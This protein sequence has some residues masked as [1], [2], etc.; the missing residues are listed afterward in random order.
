MYFSDERSETKFAKVGGSAT[1]NSLTIQDIGHLPYH[2][3]P[4]R[5]PVE[6]RY[7][8]PNQL[9]ELPGDLVQVVLLGIDL[10]LQELRNTS[11]AP[12]PLRVYL[13]DHHPAH[14]DVER[15]EHLQ[16]LPRVQDGHQLGYQHVEERRVR[17]VPHHL[18]DE[19]K[20]PSDVLELVEHQVFLD[21]SALAGPAYHAR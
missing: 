16:R 1:C 21:Q 10:V 19:V 18:A 3:E 6:H 11:L 15:L 7:D 13:V 9:P 2:L 14:G 4:L 5:L 20:P 12:Q 8:A 17:L